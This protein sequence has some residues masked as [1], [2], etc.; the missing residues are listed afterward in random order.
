VIRALALALA[1]AGPAG[2]DTLGE[3]VAA[4]VAADD[5]AAM[6]ALA[7]LAAAG[8]TRAMLFLGAIEPRPLVTAFMLDLGRADRNALLRQPGGLSGKSWLI[9]IPAG[10]PQRPLADALLAARAGDPLP[11][12]AAG[13]TGAAVQPLLRMF[14]EVPGRLSALVLTMPL[15][16]DLR[17]GIWLDAIAAADSGGTAWS[18]L[19]ARIDAAEPAGSLARLIVAGRH[20]RPPSAE[21]AAGI[22]LTRGLPLDPD[23]LAGTRGIDAA[24]FAAGLSLAQAALMAA[25]EA[26]AHRA[27]CAPCP[28]ISSCTLALW[29]GSG[30]YFG[31]VWPGTPLDAFVPPEVWQDS[32]RRQAEI[33]HAAKQAPEIADAC[34]AGIV[35]GAAP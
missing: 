19:A 20:N 9:A 24:T 12:L 13:Q 30:A 4:W 35:G 34:A 29:A 16:A 7:G 33:R 18:L 3:A 2:A 1:L 8:D 10:D 31:A 21:A 15:S 11:L 27:L 5:A 26:A 17:A 22:I 25:P 32:P 6:P 28:E 23:W 14:N